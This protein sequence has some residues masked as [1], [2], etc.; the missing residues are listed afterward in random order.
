M[1]QYQSTGAVMTVAS[2]ANSQT[3]LAISSAA[4]IPSVSHKSALQLSYLVV[5]CTM[6]LL[7]FERHRGPARLLPYAKARASFLCGT[8]WPL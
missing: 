7:V 6:Y 8:F 5:N 1:A 4:K 3:I 2:A